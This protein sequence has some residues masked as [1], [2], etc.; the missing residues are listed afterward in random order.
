L[1]GVVV[2][3]GYFDSSG[4]VEDDRSL[5]R[6]V[7]AVEPSFLDG[8]AEFDSKVGFGLREGFRRVLELPL[9]AVSASDSLVDE[10]TNEFDVLDSESDGLFLR[11]AEYLITEDGSGGVVHVEDDVASVFQRLDRSADEGFT[12]G[13]KDLTES[14]CR[15]FRVKKVSHKRKLT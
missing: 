13:R 7:L 8:V 2:G 4:Q 11:V 6:L 14:D 5:L 9:S 10:L 3:S 15:E 12:S 1:I